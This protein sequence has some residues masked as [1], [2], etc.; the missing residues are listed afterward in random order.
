M[1]EKVGDKVRDKVGGAAAQRVQGLVEGSGA[2][3]KLAEEL[4]GMLRANAHKVARIVRGEAEQMSDFALTVR[5]R[6]N[7]LIT[8]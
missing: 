8:G 7:L 4:C 5:M 1:A 2:V 3:E 6:E